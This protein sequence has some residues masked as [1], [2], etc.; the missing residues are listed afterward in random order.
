M[1]IEKKWL[2]LA[3]ILIGTFICTLDGSI[4]SVALHTISEKLKVDIG[5]VQWIVTSYLLVISTLILIFGRLSDIKG[6]KKVYQN[7]FIIFSLGSLFCG[8]SFGITALII[9]RLI[10]GVGAAMMMSCSYGIVTMIF[11]S[12]E[13]GKAI[14]ILG[15]V[16]SLGSMVGPS[17][18]GILVE[19]FS[20]QIIFLINV[21]IG[22]FGYFVGAKI[23]PTEE[24]KGNKETFD[25]KGGISYSVTIIPLIWAVVSAEKLGWG[26][27]IIISALLISTVSFI[28]FLNIELKERFPL[29]DLKLFKN[30]M[31]SVSII[32]AFISFMAIFC[33]NIIHP[34]YLQGV[35]KIN[36]QKAGLLMIVFPIVVAFVAP[37]SGYMSDKIGSRIITLVGL[38]ITTIG[39]ILMASLNDKSTYVVLIINMAILGMGNGLFQAPNNSFVM[40]SVPK[41]KLGIAGSINSLIRNLG[42]VFGI[43]LSMALFYNRV[44]SKVGDG[45]FTLSEISNDVFIYAMR[46]VYLSAAALAFVGVIMTF[47]RIIDKNDK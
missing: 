7:G 18:G 27:P 42:M 1:K 29:V 13:R 32:C 43:A 16:V 2:I 46:F 5:S 47:V 24:V 14:G 19:H 44:S 25:F 36:P 34:F 23:L 30:K 4:V 17:L 22:I 45:I 21:P 9:S 40:S 39:L 11:G 15:T 41:N 28:I 6:K 38:L 12:K 37:I 20:W 8:F 33:T 10:Q 3:N 26:N 31:F 35:L